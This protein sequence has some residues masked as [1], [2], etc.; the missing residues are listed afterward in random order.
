MAG[1]GLLAIALP[2]TAWA[3]TI[4]FD[5][6][7]TFE[8]GAAFLPGSTV[9]L[10]ITEGVATGADLMISAGSNS[11]AETI[12]GVPNVLNG[13]PPYA[14]PL[15]WLT[16]DGWTLTFFPPPPP[17]PPPDPANPEAP[18]FVGFLGGPVGDVDYFNGN[19]P[20]EY[21]G[22]SPNGVDFTPIPEP[23]AISLLA[24][25][26]AGLAGI[27]VRKKLSAPA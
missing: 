7:G 23:S 24:L 8:N 22:G 11:P 12:L 1:A 5:V 19:S 3:T 9:T 25:G 4:T 18:G 6:T 10:D 21:S 2:A 26:L 15:E 14:N 17:V 16:A 27:G 13:Y 20:P